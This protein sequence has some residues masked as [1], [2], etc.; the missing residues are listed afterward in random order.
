MMTSEGGRGSSERSVLTMVANLAH[1][2][3][4]LI[5]LTKIEELWEGG[6]DFSSLVFLGVFQ[7]SIFL[8]ENK[9]HFA[10]HP[11]SQ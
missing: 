9:N 1:R 3:E 11:E 2:S 8:E 6:I 10:E 7:C 4:I 5:H